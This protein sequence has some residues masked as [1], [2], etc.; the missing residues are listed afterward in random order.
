MSDPTEN[1]SDQK[2]KSDQDDQPGSN[3][4][5]LQPLLKRPKSDFAEDYDY[6]YYQALKSDHDWVGTYSEDAVL[7]DG[8]KDGVL[9]PSELPT[10]PPSSVSEVHAVLFNEKIPTEVEDLCFPFCCQVCFQEFA[11]PVSKLF[12]VSILA[13][14]VDS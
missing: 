6:E 14:T 3:K 12:S 9:P 5:P 11:S 13:D 7:E 2:R 10:G 8:S 1:S 4:S